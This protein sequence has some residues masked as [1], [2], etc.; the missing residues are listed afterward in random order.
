MVVKDFIPLTDPK[1]TIQKEVKQKQS[2]AEL[3]T[4]ESPGKPVPASNFVKKKPTKK[5]PK[6]KSS[7]SKKTKEPSF[8]PIKNTILIITE[9]PQ[10]AQKIASALGTPIKRVEEG[11]SYSSSHVVEKSSQ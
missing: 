8:K 2:I 11:V 4:I 10:A 1:L 3:T 7:L 6:E 9:K 5:T